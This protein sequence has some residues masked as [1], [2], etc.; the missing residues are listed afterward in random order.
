[1]F[2]FGA[3]YYPE[4]W[5]EERWPEDVRLMQEAGFNVVRLAEF[6]WSKME[7]SEGQ[8][9]F[10]WL[11][12]AIELLGMH[13]IKSVLGTPTA[14]PPPWVMAE[15]EMFIVGE[16]GVRL[17]YGLRRE[18]CPTNETFRRHSVRITEAMV[19][20]YKDNPNIIGWQIDNEFGD[21][22]FCSL[23]QKAFQQWLENKYGRLDELNTRWGTVF[24]SHV[25]TDWSQI[26]A[27]LNTARSH[28]PGLALDY[29]RFMSDT[30]V[31]YQKLQIDVIRERCPD[32]FVTHN[33]MGFKYP[34]LNYFDMS[35][36]LD[37]VSWD[38]YW[39]M[40][41]NLDAKPD[42]SFAAL[43]HDAMRGLKKKNFWVMEQQSGGGG[44][45][46]VANP[47]K[48]GQLRLWAY[49]SVAHGADG[50]VF[51]RWR[52]CRFGTEEYWHG[53]LDHHGIPGRRYDETA[54]M[55]AEIKK[56]GEQ[57]VESQIKSKVAMLQSYDTRFA[58]QLQQN[59]PRF[60]YEKHFQ[61]VY[62]GFFSRQVPV[63][64]IS[65]A[66]SLS[67]YQVVVVPT[68]YI[69]SEETAADLEKFAKA[70][71]LVV[72]TSLTGVKDTFNTVVNQKL[73]GLV[74]E[75][76]GVEVEEYISL[77][78]DGT[79]NVQFGLPDVEDDFNTSVW[80]EVLELK[81]AEVAAW[82]TEDYYADK[83]AVTLNA[84]GDGKVGYVGTMGDAD[85]YSAIAKWIIG[86]A[87]IMPL[88]DV[89]PG[90]EVAERWQGAQRLLFLL[91][92]THTVQN[93]NLPRPYTDLISDQRLEGAVELGSNDVM[94]LTECD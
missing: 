69:L 37:F 83:P 79:N 6:A 88:L 49:Q 78:S 24:W 51:F 94:I 26:P 33:L 35:A 80:A 81:G 76:C 2:Y 84:V 67:G 17:T 27:P 43:N 73:P 63:D 46:I 1:M 61:D 22:C 66:D 86:L 15:P 31:D 85:Y 39:Q 92:H 5:P 60:Q 41:W 72:F 82:Y 30:Y 48:P 25:Y 38:N 11:D 16:D 44:W 74:A 55:G 59:N 12:R 20:H 89:P 21:R 45:E 42:P 65:E 58:F 57:I 52:T 36:D 40:Q 10:G 68:M 19:E 50:I 71:G 75:M 90:V 34:N 54:Q 14:S 47:P 8:F 28:N 7:P 9:D 4:H 56:I 70:G 87:G 29:R 3:D 18:Y 77:P 91:N 13:G 53:V 62:N 32:H 93:L 23:C 64:V